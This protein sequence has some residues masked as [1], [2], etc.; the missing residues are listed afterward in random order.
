M[1]VL[2]KMAF[3]R[4]G[5]PIEDPMLSPYDYY[6]QPYQEGS[7]FAARWERNHRKRMLIEVNKYVNVM[8]K[9]EW[10][11]F[12]KIPM[13]VDLNDRPKKRG[14]GKKRKVHTRSA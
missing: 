3:N 4:D 9:L 2:E 14:R 10:M 6:S 13:K 1:P 11:C 5:Y 12:G 7:A 8:P